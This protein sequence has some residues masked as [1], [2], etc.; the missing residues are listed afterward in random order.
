M[1]VDTNVIIFE[2]IKEEIKRGK[3][4]QLAVA[5]GY[6]KSLAPVLDAHVTSLLTA[7]ILAYFGLG[8]VLGFATTQIIGLLLSLFWWYPGIPVNIRCMDK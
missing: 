7:F 2:R 6:K 8:P 1:A 5:D 3:N 4:Y